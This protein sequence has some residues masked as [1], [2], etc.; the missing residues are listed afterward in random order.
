[1]TSRRAELWCKSNCPNQPRRMPGRLA[2]FPARRRAML[3]VLVLA[4]VGWEAYA[5]DLEPRAYAN[6]P[7]GLNFLIAGY[8]YLT[9]GVATDPSLPLH[10]AHLQVH[11]TVLAYALSL[12]VWGKS[13][14]VEEV[15][16]AVTCRSFLPLAS[17]TQMSKAPVRLLQTELCLPSGV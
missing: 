1:M 4:A 8:G 12:D 6:I 2:P 7:T 14:K 3:L 17:I 5:Q 13:G 10:N 9:G 11:I 16:R 15:P